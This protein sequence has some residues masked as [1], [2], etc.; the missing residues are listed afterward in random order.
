M[1]RACFNMLLISSK[2]KGYLRR[3]EFLFPCFIWKLQSPIEE[4][5]P[6]LLRNIQAMTTSK[7]ICDAVFEWCCQPKN[8]SICT[9][10]ACLWGSP[11]I[12][13]QSL[14]TNCSWILACQW[15][16]HRQTSEEGTWYSEPSGEKKY[17]IR[18]EKGRKGLQEVYSLPLG[19]H[20]C[21]FYFFKAWAVVGGQ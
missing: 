5:K 2:T 7:S 8:C 4:E 12:S 1:R 15:S 9:V 14:A 20:A 18:P 19:Y 3:T 13:D 6:C 21:L 11:F 16:I 17:L 10:S